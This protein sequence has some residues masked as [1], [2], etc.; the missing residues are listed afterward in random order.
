MLDII[1][2]LLLLYLV[3]RLNH[4]LQNYLKMFHFK[5]FQKLQELHYFK[6]QNILNLKYFRHQ[7][8]GFR[9]IFFLYVQLLKKQHFYIKMVLY[10][11]LYNHYHCC[12]YW[13]SLLLDF[14]DLDINKLCYYYCWMFDLNH[15]FQLINFLNS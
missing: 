9:Y 5:I 4:S 3:E 8:E 1:L 15:L 11:G 2:L 6:N 7:T 10:L 12:L 13:L 14:Q